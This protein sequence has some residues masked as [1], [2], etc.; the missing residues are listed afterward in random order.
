MTF[1]VMKYLPVVVLLVS[2][3]SASSVT[4]QTN[5]F[6]RDTL[7]NEARTAAQWNAILPGAGHLYAGNPEQGAMLFAGVATPLVVGYFVADFESCSGD[8]CRDPNEINHTPMYIGAGMAAAVYIL[9]VMDVANEVER[10]NTLAVSPDVVK[11]RA[12]L[13]LR[14][15][16]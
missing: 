2:M 10:Q 11:G 8:I 6:D 15:S 16:L 13:S 9:G 7:S 14:V 1:H 3:I 4:A 5:R 12:G